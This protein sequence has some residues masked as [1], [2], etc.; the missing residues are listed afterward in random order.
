MRL[1]GYR[2]AF[3][4]DQSPSLTDCS[5]LTLGLPRRRLHL[6]VRALGR[7]ALLLPCGG[8]RGIADSALDVKARNNL[9]LSSTVECIDVMPLR[10]SG[11]A[12]TWDI[13]ALRPVPGESH[14]GHHRT[15]TW[16]Q[17]GPP[18]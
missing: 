3:P 9:P 14:P 11:E 8:R 16:P 17:V 13:T 18:Q 5:S 6:L 7:V 2:A 12:L 4:P 10:A 1:A 15:P